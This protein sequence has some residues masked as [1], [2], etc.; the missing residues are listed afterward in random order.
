MTVYKV[1]SS[2]SYEATGDTSSFNVP[3]RL[4]EPGDLVVT[5]KQN[6]VIRLL[7][8]YSDYSVRI[9]DY[10]SAQVEFSTPPV[11]ELTLT[12]QL[13]MTQKVDFS[14]TG[15]VRTETLE[16]ALDR[17]TSLIHQIT[18][19]ESNL[20]ALQRDAPDPKDYALW[21]DSSQGQFKYWTG[22]GWE[23]T[24]GDVSHKANKVSSQVDI[25]N[26]LAALTPDGDLKDSGV[27][28]SDFEAPSISET[29][30]ALS[31]LPYHK[32]SLIVGTEEGPATLPSGELG[33]TLIADS[34]MPS[35]LKWAN[36]ERRDYVLIDHWST[37][38][39]PEKTFTWDPDEYVSV[40]LIGEGI[41]PDPTNKYLRISVGYAQGYW[42]GYSWNLQKVFEPEPE[43]VAGKKHIII[44]PTMNPTG[45]VQADNVV[46]AAWFQLSL[47]NTHLTITPYFTLMAG[48]NIFQGSPDLY[49]AFGRCLPVVTNRPSVLRVSW[50]DAANFKT[51]GKIM[52]YGLKRPN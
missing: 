38:E 37:S 12:R 1:Q 29:L 31:T 30:Q 16:D 41:R 17:V 51:G 44:P 36:N 47:L 52:L 50:S 49:S 2:I 13:S 7:G 6:D 28:V 19:N 22:E 8:L 3:F 45:G 10:E 33:Q 15:E 21:Y 34:G 14:E 24:S 25:D 5:L 43:I 18:Q 40:D 11:G 27:S 26:H 9:L 42:S 48:V 4:F 20:V 35:G 39:I 32:G 23:A 46:Q